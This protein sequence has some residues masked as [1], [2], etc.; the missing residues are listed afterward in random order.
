[1]ICVIAIITICFLIFKLS[2]R[3]HSFWTNQGFSQLSPKFLVG[4][5]GPRVFPKSS[6][7]EFFCDLYQKTKHHRFIGFYIGYS[8]TLLV[9]DVSLI[10]KILK[11]NYKNFQ[12][13]FHAYN[14]KLNPLMGHMANQTGQKWRNIRTKV[15]PSF[16]TVKLKVN[17]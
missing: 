15:S 14:L 16:S 13:R 9:N 3:Q 4:N 10:K 2:Q 5:L 11:T 7:G 17:F 1:M 8:P 6:L 12:D